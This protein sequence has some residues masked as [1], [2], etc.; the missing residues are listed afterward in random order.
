M[1]PTRQKKEDNLV[2]YDPN[3]ERWSVLAN[4]SIRDHSRSAR[5]E[6]AGLK[7]QEDVLVEKLRSFKKLYGAATSQNEKKKLLQRFQD[8]KDAKGWQ[9][10]QRSS[11]AISK[12]R[13]FVPPSPGAN[14]EKTGSLR[15]IDRQWS[16]LP[17]RPQT[18]LGFAGTSKP[19]TTG[20]GSRYNDW[21]EN[22]VSPIWSTTERSSSNGDSHAGEEVSSP[23]WRTN[24][25]RPQTRASANEPSTALD[26]GNQSSRD[27]SEA[28][29]AET[30][31][32]QGQHES[33]RE[34][35]G[36]GPV[37]AD[38]LS[39][40]DRSHNRSDLARSRISQR[41]SEAAHGETPSST[42]AVAARE[43]GL[44]ADCDVVLEG[45]CSA[46]VTEGVE[47]ADRLASADESRHSNLDFVNSDEQMNSRSCAP[48]AFPVD[49]ALSKAASSSNLV[50][51]RLRKA[52]S[53]VLQSATQN[54]ANLPAG[55]R[56]PSGA[57]STK[58]TGYSPGPAS[59][60]GSRSASRNSDEHTSSPGATKRVSQLRCSANSPPK[61]I[62]ARP[63]SS[64][65]LLRTSLPSLGAST[66]PRGTS[67]SE[68][69]ASNAWPPRG[70]YDRAFSAPN[71]R[72][73][74]PSMQGG[75]SRREVRTRVAF[76]WQQSVVYEDG[77]PV[78]RQRMVS[79]AADASQ[80][81]PSDKQYDNQDCLICRC[82]TEVQ[83]PLLHRAIGRRKLLFKSYGS[84]STTYILQVPLLQLWLGFTSLLILE[85]RQSHEF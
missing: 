11:E 12:E 21:E 84:Q 57:E 69:A 13:S 31:R 51:P 65:G 28:E 4:Q 79:G 80:T 34:E 70:R 2:A 24:A 74:S 3:Q 37:G 16:H 77:V 35:R 62:P 49:D 50:S 42:G 44:D 26:C 60:S 45:L 27:Y 56:T 17:A 82:C 73:A 61:G 14:F 9:A 23:D 67:T 71:S 55:G 22:T 6:K 46:A 19:S 25:S 36:S 18:A 33:T 38:Q 29:G 5:K 15:L 1:G 63:V 58:V 40:K 39:P 7:N 20:Q 78:Q 76:S 10:T 64:I 41:S 75:A 30:W 32:Q 59:K 85:D 8:R 72:S 53:R 66:R 81:M 83:V 47:Q 52:D 43:F 48:P 54:E 68:S